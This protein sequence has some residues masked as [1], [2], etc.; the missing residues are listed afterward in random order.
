MG[1]LQPKTGLN[2]VSWVTFTTRSPIKPIGGVV[3]VQPALTALQA[4]GTFR[5]MDIDRLKR[6]FEQAYGRAPAL[7]VRAPGR[8]NLIGEHTDYNDGFVLP[9]AIERQVAGC[10]APRPDKIVNFASC[11]AD[12]TAS[13]DLG[14]PITPGEPD[15]ANYC[16]GVAAGLVD[17]GVELSGADVLFDS[18]IAIGAGLSSSAALEVCTAMALLAASGDLHA[19]PDRQLALLCQRAE[20]EFAGAPCGIMDQSI[21]VMAR[22]GQA[23]LLDCR[24]GETEQVP[25]DDPNTVLLVVDTRVRHEIGGGEYGKRRRR[26]ADAAGKLGLTALRDAD[27]RMIDEAAASGVLEAIETRRA[28]HVVSEIERTL[29]AV[30]ALKKGEYRH[31]GELMYA[32]HD[33]L[34]NDFEVSCDELDEVVAQASRC[35]GVYGARMT[36]GGFGGSAIVLVDSRLAEGVSR[37]IAAGFESRFGRG[38][39]IF[40]TRAAAGAGLV[41]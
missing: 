8:V 18:D 27:R 31:F 19:V 32:S 41:E 7:V 36:G 24:S 4:P 38:C 13:V 15:W 10:V 5:R 17:C 30:E 6:R 22:A 1:R 37:E 16:L 25:F 20:N 29:Q 40:A 34:R 3:L 28:R 35:D 12:R 23:L 21:S 9:I 39:G 26:C 2:P 33:S 11:Q 14:G